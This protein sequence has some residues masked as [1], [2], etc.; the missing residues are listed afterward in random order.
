MTKEIE[1]GPFE[2]SVNAL[3]GAESLSSFFETS[4]NKVDVFNFYIALHC[5]SPEWLRGIHK[6]TDLPRRIMDNDL[7]FKFVCPNSEAGRAKMADW[8]VQHLQHGWNI[9]NRFVLFETEIDSIQYQMT[10]DTGEMDV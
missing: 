6:E 4:V 10:W 8:V 2:K 7:P 1:I 3:K 5:K 9:N